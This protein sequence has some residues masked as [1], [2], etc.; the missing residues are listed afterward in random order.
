MTHLSLPSSH[1]SHTNMSGHLM[2]L[3]IQSPHTYTSIL[4]ATLK[5]TPR[6]TER[7]YFLVVIVWIENGG[8]IATH[9]K[10]LISKVTRILF[11]I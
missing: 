2:I 7:F 4:R 6:P 8:A 11:D 5:K 3:P 9:S 1:V 10:G